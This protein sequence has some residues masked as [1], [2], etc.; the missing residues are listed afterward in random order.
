MPAQQTLGM[1]ISY[2]D[3][4]WAPAGGMQAFANTFVRFIREHG[5][6][7]HR[8][9]PVER[10]RVENGRAVGITL[11]DGTRLDADRVI[12]AADLRHTCLEL[13]GREHLP[14]A[15]LAKL[16][17]A[18]PSEPVFAVFLGLR[19]SPKLDA[20]FGRFHEPHIIFTCADGRVIQIVWLDKDDPSIAPDGHHA[21]FVGWLDQ[22]DDWLPLKGDETAYCAHKIAVAAELITRAGEFLPGLREHIVVQE[23]ASPLTYERYTANWQGATTGWSWNPAHAPRFKFPKDL[24]VEDFYAAG[25]FTFNPGGVPTAMITAW[26][27]AREISKHSPESE[28]QKS[29]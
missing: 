14:V 1:W 28:R 17:A 23:A 21:L 29:L 5:G 25:H 8:G 7:V 4:T 11:R 20:A 27:I 2:F 3:D 19:A 16:E 10:I 12:S 13:I 15:T 26:Y 22:Y 9:M 6:Q 18:R 24:P